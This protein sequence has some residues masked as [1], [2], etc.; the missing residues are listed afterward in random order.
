MNQTQ[1]MQWGNMPCVRLDAGGYTALIAPDLGS[2]VVRLRDETNGIE[3]FRFKEDNT[4]EEL[5]KSAEVWGLP[6]LYLPNRFADGV[7]KTSDAVYHLPVNEKAPYNNHIHGFLHKRS[8]TVVEHAADANCAWCVT[9]YV[10][11]EHD[12]F[13]QYLPVSFR[14]RFRFTLS[15]CGLEYEFTLENLSAD[16]QLPVSVATHTT[17]NSPFVTGAREKDERITAPIGK[18]WLLNARCLP[19]LETA[20]LTM[21]DL[22]YRSGARCPVLQNIDNEMYFAE[23]MSVDGEDLYGILMEDLDSGKRICYEVGEEYRFWIFW[24][25]KGFNGYFCP[26]PMSAMI[27]APNLD[28]PPAL[29]GYRELAPGGKTAFRQHFY[30]LTEE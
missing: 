22:E 27:D 1:M 28:I 29:S 24:N 11:D 2:N 10:Y 16:K 5:I 21:Q 8:H 6:T 15:A 18:R 19:T 3:F 13:F 9:E 20:E 17:I 25:D 23:H 4:F 14:A 7:L 30:T 26:E 12:P